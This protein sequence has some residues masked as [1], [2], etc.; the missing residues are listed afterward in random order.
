MTLESL[1][2]YT[3]FNIQSITLSP[4]F[5]L[6]VLRDG[7]ISVVVICGVESGNLKYAGKISCLWLVT[8]ELWL[9]LYMFPQAIAL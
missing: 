8:K 5:N 4:L 6:H 1:F 3:T 2:V 9:I 7:I